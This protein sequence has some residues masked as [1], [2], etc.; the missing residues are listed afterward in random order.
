LYGLLAARAPSLAARAPSLVVELN[1]AVAVSMGEGSRQGLAIVDA[2]AGYHLLPSVRDLLAR[3][4]RRAEAQEEFARAAGLSRNEQKR[5]LL[6]GRA[7][8]RET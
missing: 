8:A 2:L 1:R 5:Q 6:L 3:L 7:A 4:G